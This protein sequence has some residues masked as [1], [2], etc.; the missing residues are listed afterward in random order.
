MA[1]FR[2]FYN[3]YAKPAF[4]T[5]SGIFVSAPISYNGVIYGTANNPYRGMIYS[6]NVSGY[7]DSYSYYFVNGNGDKVAQYASWSDLYSTSSYNECLCIYETPGATGGLPLTRLAGKFR[8]IA[9]KSYASSLSAEIDSTHITMDFKYITDKGTIYDCWGFGFYGRGVSRSYSGDSVPLYIYILPKNKDMTA[10]VK[11]ATFRSSAI[12]TV[13]VPG[14]FDFGAGKDIPATH[15]EAIRALSDDVSPIKVTYDNKTIL[16]TSGG[17]QTFNCKG[18][19]AKTDIVVKA[20]ENSYLLYRD[21]V[22]AIPAGKTAVLNCANRKFYTDVE[23]SSVEISGE[24]ELAVSS[25]PSYDIPIFSKQGRQTVKFRYAIHSGGPYGSYG[26][27]ADGF[28]IVLESDGEVLVYTSESGNKGER[29]Y[30]G[31]KLR[32]NFGTTPQRVSKLF[33]DWLFKYATKEE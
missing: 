16:S 5:R 11:V 4:L 6:G 26:S 8:L 19:I 29:A 33:S 14:V 17:A 1:F 10:A 27:Y 21:K 22:E 30:V 13:E 9:Q 15:V 3:K 28:G 18:L 25:V 20:L 7:G 12:Y 2:A 31:Q 24:Y 23:L 32:L